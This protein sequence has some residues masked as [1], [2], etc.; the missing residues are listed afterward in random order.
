MPNMFKDKP[1]D[2]IFKKEDAD[3][4]VCFKLNFQTAKFIY[5][6]ILYL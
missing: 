5:L 2:K 4:Q 3:N 6:F 1:Q